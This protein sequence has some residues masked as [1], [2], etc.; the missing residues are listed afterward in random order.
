[1]QLT[2]N[3]TNGARNGVTSPDLAYIG[4][5]V[6]VLR[7]TFESGKT[8]P[9]EFRMQQLESLLKLLDVEC[10]AITDALN[11]DLGKPRLEAW[12]AEVADC[13]AGIKHIKKHLKKWMKPERVTTALVAMPGKSRIVREPLGVG[14]IIT[15]WNYPFSLAINPLAGAI[16][17]GNCVMIKPSEVAPA[18]SA[19]LA[20]IIP[21]YFD[22]SYVKVIE[23]A[24]T[25]TT[26]VLAQRFDHIFYTGNGTVGR[27]V[28]AAAA[29]NLT[30]VTLELGGK[31]P[32]IVDEHGDMEVQVRRIMWAKSYNC[33][34]TCVAP[35]YVLVH[36]NVHDKFID[37]VKRVAQE[38]WGDNA[39]ASKDYGR[40]VNVRH[41][42]RLMALLPGSGEVV[43]G[44]KADEADRFIAPTVLK[45]VPEH[46][47][48]MRDEIF[49]P[50][51]PVIK[52]DSIEHAIQFIR[53]RPK[54]LALYLF[55]SSEQSYQA[56]VDNTSS[57]GLLVNH[58]IMHLAV[59]GLPF[60]GVG[61]SGMG[62]YHGKHSFEA[63]SHR[64]AVLKKGTALD[65]S[66]LYPP[67]TASKETW[68][69]RLM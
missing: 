16:A 68:M 4:E 28:M 61:E 17:A 53:A 8:R 31:S 3:E 45:D 14:L 21:K 62:A 22:P 19:L 44:G 59:P 40:I 26:E 65:P 67:Y 63:F 10:D 33:G 37:T 20:K 12:G 54:P 13:A 41:H 66:I 1:M 23:G 30:P 60:G 58:A 9:Y 64:K 36:K 5:A 25:E 48:V 55:S 39:Q 11:T 52:V 57:G 51:L 35:D 6:K 56:V 24:V 43:V 50:I 34:Q 18:T 42:R 29:K 7:T 38:F 49:G 47:P 32:C 69:R 46:A 2:T 15:P 27:I